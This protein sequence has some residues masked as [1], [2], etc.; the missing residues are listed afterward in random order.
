GEGTHGGILAGDRLQVAE[1][2]QKRRNCRFEIP[3]FRWGKKKRIQ[4]RGHRGNGVHR[5][6]KI[7]RR[8]T[9]RREKRMAGVDLSM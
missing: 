4:H 7:Q 5:E 8:G 2:R 1:D 3:D 6:E 9:G